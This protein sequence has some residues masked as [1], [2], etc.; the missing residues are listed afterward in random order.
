M[1]NSRKSNGNLKENVVIKYFH[2]YCVH[3][4]RLYV[5][6]N[7]LWL[8]FPHPFSPTL[9]LHHCVEQHGA[10]P[11]KAI[12]LV[13]DKKLFHCIWSYN[14]G[15]NNHHDCINFTRNQPKI[16]PRHDLLEKHVLHSCWIGSLER[17]KSRSWR[18]HWHK[19]LRR[20]WDVARKWYDPSLW[21]QEVRRMPTNTVLT[22]IELT[23]LKSLA[24]WYVP[25]G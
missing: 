6:W 14:L 25:W 19:K 18:A 21:Y 12:F 8:F 3:L 24:P 22:N 20:C 10:Y 17:H 11:Q 16:G 7:Y 2:L 9:K 23:F 15:N 13:S 5:M 4:H 1:T